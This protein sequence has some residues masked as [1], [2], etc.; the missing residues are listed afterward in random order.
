MPVSSPTGIFAHGFNVQ[1]QQ[2]VAADRDLFDG[3]LPID[4]LP[5]KVAATETREITTDKPV[6]TLHVG[7]YARDGVKKFAA[8]APNGKHVDGDEIIIPVEQNC[9]EKP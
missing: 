6:A 9:L 8:F 5:Q 1:D 3:Y 2:V 7:L 4:L